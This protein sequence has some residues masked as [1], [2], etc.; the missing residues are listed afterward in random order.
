MLPV[1]LVRSFSDG[2]ASG[3]EVASR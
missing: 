2:N 1:I 3:F